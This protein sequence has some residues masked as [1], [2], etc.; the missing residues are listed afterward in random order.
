M[1]FSSI[2]MTALTNRTNSILL[3]VFLSASAPSG[4]F[5][6]E[7]FLGPPTPV[8]H[9]ARDWTLSISPNYVNHPNAY[10]RIVA[11][12]NSMVFIGKHVS[13]N[14]NIA[15]G[16]GY[17]QFGT[18]L[19]G[20][21]LFLFFGLVLSDEDADPS[22][23]LFYLAMLALT[24]ENMNFHIPVY[25]HFEISPYFS[26]LRIKYIEEGYGGA[27]Y[28][29]NANLVGGVRLNIFIS[30]RFYIAPYAETTRDWG[31][32]RNGIWGVNGGMHAGFYFRQK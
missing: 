18:G 12:L 10:P 11:G 1:K 29:W 4:L 32:G 27:T 23:F 21:P 24:F 3:F 22:A 5:A 8:M 16:Q 20:L 15:G 31:H 26:L 25:S 9:E 19:V 17:F 28:P 14:A 30:D 7:D 2:R 6:Q 13:L